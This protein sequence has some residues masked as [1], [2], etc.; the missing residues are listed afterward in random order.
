[1]KF[2]FNI[3]LYFIMI[4]KMIQNN[5]QL[6]NS[7]NLSEKEEKEIISDHQKLKKI[8][9]EIANELGNVTTK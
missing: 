7:D 4:Q 3:G 6:L 2:F 1:M 8:E 5:I 9:V